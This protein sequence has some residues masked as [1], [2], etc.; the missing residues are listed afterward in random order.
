MQWN[1]RETR[2]SKQAATKSVPEGQMTIARQFIAGFGVW[3]FLSAAAENR[4]AQ[5]F[6]LGLEFGRFLVCVPIARRA[7]REQPRA[8]ALGTTP[9]TKSP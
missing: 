6:G 8:S 7:N 1:H 4:T 9:T 2:I 5:A 3:T